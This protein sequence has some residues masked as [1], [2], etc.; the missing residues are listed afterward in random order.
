MRLSHFPNAVA[1][2]GHDVMT[3]FLDSCR[4][5]GLGVVANDLSAD[6]AVIW[7][8]LWAG[9]LEPNH[10][11][12]QQF[13]AQGKP[14]VVLEVGAL[15]RGTTWKVLFNGQRLWNPDPDA[16]PR[17]KKLGVVLQPWRQQGRHVVLALQRGDSEQ[18]SGMPAVDQWCDQVIQKLRA[19][20][21]RPIMIRNHPRFR[22]NTN[23]PGC[24][25][26]TPQPVANTYD[27]FDL[28]RCLEQAW[29]LVNHNSHPAIEAVIQGIPI[30]VDASS[31]AAAV[32]N[33]DISDIENPRRP[34]REQWLESLCDTEWT[35]PE[36]KSGGPLDRLLLQ[37]L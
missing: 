28:D 22:T 32:G 17:S 33:L 9:R 11:V 23:F 6:V 20:T 35:L 10:Q 36:I 26:D 13:R 3:A 25:V 24:V 18:W 30:F 14:V 31:D 34:E 29:A 19:C 16:E 37:W 12:W 4:Q 5:R 15:R 8:Q 21:K 1:R 7:S 2:N 27:S